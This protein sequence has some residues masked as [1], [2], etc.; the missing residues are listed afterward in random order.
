MR[1]R[2]TGV[3]ACAALVAVVAALWVGGSAARPSPVAMAAAGKV[4]SSE[5][6]IKYTSKVIVVPRATV[7]K[8]LKGISDTTGVFKFVH[9]SGQLTKLK[10]GRVMLLQGADALLVT[11]LKHSHGD[12]LVSTKPANLTD[13][14]SSGKISFA[15]TPNFDQAVG[16]PIVSTSSTASDKAANDFT[17]PGYP[18]VGSMPDSTD[19]QIADAPSISASGHFGMYGYS[20]SF[21]PGGNRID[22]DGTLCF[23]T[24]SVCGNGPSTGVSD[25]IRLTGYLI[26]GNAKGGITVSAGK[27]TG[28]DFTL[29]NFTAHLDYHYTVLRGDGSDG[30]AHPPVFH[31]PIGIDYTIPGEIPIYL[32]LQTNF[33]VILGVT[34]KN[35]VME[36]GLQLTA[37]GGSDTIKQSGKSVSESESGDKGFDGDLLDQADGESNVSVGPG[38]AEFAMQFPKMGVGLGF[39]SANAIAYI[40]LIS[41]VGQVT[42]GAVS[43]YPCSTYDL[44][45]SLGA[46]LEA[47]IGLG[48]F[49]LSYATPRKVIFPTNGKPF[50]F[51]DGDPECPS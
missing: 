5:K 37:G 47:Q 48:K 36:G 19:A 21:T 33:Y 42:G 14:I 24:T 29:G 31:V 7:K 28:S 27:E 10:V 12:L 18:Y 26:V 44:S 39:T 51:S 34:S 20:L 40:D 15:G 32:K 17:R 1:S 45:A 6:G 16:Q 2:L 41:A 3:V 8:E 38:A 30:D 46:G 25:E 11:K 9:P 22:V 50:S 13:V 49:G 23:A 4:N 35:S 43:L